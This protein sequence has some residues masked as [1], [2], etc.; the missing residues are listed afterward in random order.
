[1]ELLSCP[2]CGESRLVEKGNTYKCEVCGATVTAKQKEDLEQRLEQLRLRGEFVDIGRSRALLRTALRAQYVNAEEVIKHCID[3]L[4]LIP[5]DFK[6]GFFKAFYTR[7]A[8]RREYHSF[9]DEH[10]SDKLS[11]YD[12][13]TVYPF[14]ID[15][16]DFEDEAAVKDFLRAQGDS[17]L[18]QDQVA[19]ALRQR[20]I[21]N[22]LFA[23]ITRDVF[24]SHK[25]D[26]FDRIFPLI[27]QLED[28][29]F[30]CWYNERN[31]PKDIANYK[32]NIEQAI[33]SCKIFLVFASHKAMM[34]KDVQW[35]LDIAEKYEKKFRI[36]YRLDNRENTTKFK[37][38]FDGVQW[39]D[40]SVAEQGDALLKRV[41]EASKLAR[42]L[43]E[44]APVEEEEEPVREEPPKKTVK[45]AK[46]E[47]IDNKLSAARQAYAQGGMKLFESYEMALV[48]EAEDVPG[49][50]KLKEEAKRAILRMEDQM[51]GERHEYPRHLDREDDYHIEFAQRV[52]DVRSEHKNHNFGPVSSKYAALF[53][54]MNDFLSRGGEKAEKSRKKSAS[55]PSPLWGGS[56]SSSSDS[57]DSL[58]PYQKKQKRN[59]TIM[60]VIGILM[61]FSPLFF[62][63]L[64]LIILGASKIR[65]AQ[66]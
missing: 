29:G 25:S 3:I 10:K 46:K 7:S 1:M 50:K 2:R 28:D 61:L 6:A 9:L 64:I 31:L 22:D 23:N 27:Q 5:D 60:L 17:S 11:H 41:Y 51:V 56:S 39:I 57:S 20:E 34:S 33:K 24:I 43:E 54:E 62:L 35:E 40:G 32:S 14:L 16:M 13:D 4:K 8:T 63:G 47:D 55:K 37:E 18:C 52:I 48:L 45:D 44:G 26:D 49:A 15:R 58:S 12:K 30:E 19:K 65:K 42:K 21:E 36:E 66:Q 53:R 38:F 59:G